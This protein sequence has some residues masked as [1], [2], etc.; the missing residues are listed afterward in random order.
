[1]KRVAFVCMT[2]LLALV[3]SGYGQQSAQPPQADTDTG[4]VAGV[5]DIATGVTIF[6][7]IPYAAS[8]AGEWRW[9]PPQPAAKWAV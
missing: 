3:C 9:R 4:V 8:P 1:M 6:R 5:R 7:G 2:F